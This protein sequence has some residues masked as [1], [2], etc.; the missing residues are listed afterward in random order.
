MLIQPIR[1]E[2]MR[3]AQRLG[4]KCHPVVAERHAHELAR[5]ARVTSA[6][7]ALE[8]FTGLRPPEDEDVFNLLAQRRGQIA[9]VLAHASLEAYEQEAAPGIYLAIPYFVRCSDKQPVWLVN[10]TDQQ[11]TYIRRSLYA[12]ASTDDGVDEYRAAG[13]A[14][15]DGVAADAVIDPGQKLQI[16][17]YSMSWDGDFV[18][19]RRVVLLIEGQ[20]GEWLASISKLAGYLWDEHLHGLHP[21]KVVKNL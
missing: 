9:D 16:D 10:R 18:S 21:L 11:L 2:V 19:N 7:D 5:Y 1:D 12:Y 15:V 13:S 6:C 3:R 17:T 8:S 4:E 14:F 20:R